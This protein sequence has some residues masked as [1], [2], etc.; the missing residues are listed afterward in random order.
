MLLQER[1]CKLYYDHGTEEEENKCQL[2]EQPGSKV[3]ISPPISFKKKLRR[4]TFDLSSFNSTSESNTTASSSQTRNASTLRH[5]GSVSLSHSQDNHTSPEGAATTALLR[6][7]ADKNQ[8]SPV[9]EVQDAIANAQS[10]HDKRKYEEEDSC[11]QITGATTMH[12]GNFSVPA[13]VSSNISSRHRDATISFT[14]CLF[15]ILLL[16]YLIVPLLQLT[17]TIERH[18]RSIL[19][20]MQ[21]NFGIASSFLISPF[22]FQREPIDIDARYICSSSIYSMRREMSGENDISMD[23]SDSMCCYSS[24]S[25]A[26]DENNNESEQDGW[27]HFADFQDELADES[28]FI[29]SCSLSPIRNRAAVTPAVLPSCVTTLETLTEGHEEEDDDAG[30]DWSF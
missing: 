28:S 6:T 9:Q 13:D 4:S 10:L 2:I 15:E 24:S 18:A 20:E 30:D 27:G 23:L 8:K 7:T 3:S 22:S 14:Q 29:P 12:A 11:F 5:R 19:R 1:D 25:S 16:G 17:V 21:V 26:S